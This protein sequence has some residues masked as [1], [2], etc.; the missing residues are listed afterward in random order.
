MLLTLTHPLFP[1]NDNIT[2]VR[3]NTAFLCVSLLFFLSIISVKIPFSLS[4][5]SGGPCG[6]LRR[7]WGTAPTRTRPTWSRAAPGPGSTATSGGW[8]RPARPSRTRRTSTSSHS[9]I[10]ALSG[11][12]G[13]ET[14]DAPSSRAPHEACGM[15]VNDSYLVSVAQYHQVP[16]EY[17]TSAVVL[18]LIL[19]ALFGL[20]YLLIIPQYVQQVLFIS[21]SPSRPL[22][23]FRN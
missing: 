8:S 23:L 1:W 4:P 17:F 15:N 16:D 18:S 19:A 21:L 13:W 11:S 6:R 5:T 20:V 3:R 10:S 7:S 22:C 9:C 12:R 2:L 14:A